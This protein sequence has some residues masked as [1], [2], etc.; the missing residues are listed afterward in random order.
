MKT[1]RKDQGVRAFEQRDHVALAFV[2]D[3]VVQVRPIHARHRATVN[4]G[5]FEGLRDTEK[6][7]KPMPMHLVKKIIRCLAGFVCWI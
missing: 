1:K 7:E 6:N 4:P 3:N 5:A 2:G